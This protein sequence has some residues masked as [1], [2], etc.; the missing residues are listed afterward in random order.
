MKLSNIKRK[1]SIEFKGPFVG[2]ITSTLL[3]ADTLI[4]RIVIEQRGFAIIPKILPITEGFRETYIDAQKQL[5]RSKQEVL[6]AD[7]ILKRR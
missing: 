5:A 2:G 7:K 4:R 6:E 1:K 3:E